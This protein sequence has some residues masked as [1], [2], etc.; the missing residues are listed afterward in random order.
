[1]AVKPEDSPA[2]D[3][4]D[5]ERRQDQNCVARQA[6]NDPHEGMTPR[7]SKSKQLEFDV[8]PGAHAAR[9]RIATMARP[10]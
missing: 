6:T 1:M 9:M 7:L 10:C 2:K 4:G 5:S 3:N 8:E